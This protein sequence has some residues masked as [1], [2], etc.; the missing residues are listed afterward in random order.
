MNYEEAI[1]F[2]RDLGKFG[3]HV[4]LERSLALSRETGSPEQSFSIVHVAGT[5]GKGSVAAMVESVLRA[6]GFRVGLYTSPH[7]SSYTER[8][9]VAGRPI[10]RTRLAQLMTELKPVFEKIA[11]DPGLGPPTEF[12]MGTALAFL[13]FAY[14]NVDFAVVEVGLGG[15]LD[16]TNI[17]MPKVSAI[18]NISLEHT[19]ILG[20]TLEEVAGEKAG[21][22]KD[23]VPVVVGR[24]DQTALRVI[25]E[26]ASNRFAPTIVFG[27]DI[28]CRRKSWSMEGQSFSVRIGSRIYDT[29]RIPLIGA[30]QVENAAVAV[31]II[32]ALQRL[33]VDIGDQA[34]TA[35]LRL[36]SWPGRLEVLQREPLV[37]V[38][39]AHNIGGIHRLREAIPEVVERRPVTAVVGISK[40]KP[41][42]QMVC[43]ISKFADAFIATRA[44]SSRS[45][46][47]APCTLAGFAEREGLQAEAVLDPFQAVDKGLEEAGKGGAL[48]VC[49]SIY[50]VGNVRRYLLE[51]AGELPMN[52]RVVVFV[53]AFGSGKT[54]IALNYAKLMR[55]R[56]KEVAVVDFDI[57]NPYFRSREAAT[58]MQSL[59]I[60]VISSGPGLEAA[61]LPSVSSAVFR[62]FQD[63][64]LQVVFDVGGDPVGAKALAGFRQQFKEAGYDMYFVLNTN[65]PFTQDAAEARTMLESIETAS[66][67]SVTGIVSNTHMG[68]ET[69]TQDVLRGIEV[70]ESLADELDLPLVFACAHH[71]V[72]EKL[73]NSLKTRLMRLD[74][75]M[76]PPWERIS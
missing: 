70:S 8:I 39:G 38:D 26:T 49:G 76:R 51:R 35:G 73:N 9:R 5:N 18:T 50:L 11:H 46:A 47:I 75:H 4:G 58:A 44:L 24:Q 55:S 15:R 56:A 69:T 32:D 31:G 42:E 57:V 14:E 67:L 20:H 10:S 36:V 74:L 62:A 53:G 16:S 63:D 28:E 6:S 29:L 1:A 41:A 21:I 66:Q 23:G 65:R 22:I 2:L 52:H 54:E 60:G 40:D 43:E 71:D 19:G 13:H 68:K 33:G 27:R 7:L 30:H 45:G 37:L 25:E 59:G 48:V 34:L 3:I 17:V 12:E 72:A 64:T 61:D